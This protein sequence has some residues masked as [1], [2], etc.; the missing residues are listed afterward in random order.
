M[1]GSTDAR[2]NIHVNEIMHTKLTAR[3]STF[4]VNQLETPVYHFTA[5]IF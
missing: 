4:N 2:A 5:K 3:I 1:I